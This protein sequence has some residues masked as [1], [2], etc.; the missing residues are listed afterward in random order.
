MYHS[1]GVFEERFN[2]LLGCME[3]GSDLKVD[4]RNA[5]D[6][7]KEEISSLIACDEIS[8]NKSNLILSENLE[9]VKKAPADCELLFFQLE[10]VEEELKHYFLLSQWQSG[11]LRESAL[12]QKRYAAFL[13]DVSNG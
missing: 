6:L 1:L 2:M 12:L 11:L 5:F 3:S 10:Q 13:A 8:G 4:A 9:A 7:L